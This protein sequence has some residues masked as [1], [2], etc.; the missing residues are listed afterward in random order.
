M[1]GRAAPLLRLRSFVPEG[2][3][4]PPHT[5]HGDRSLRASC[6][7]PTGRVMRVACRCV[8]WDMGRVMRETR[9]E[10][11]DA[12]SQLVLAASGSLPSR[13]SRFSPGAPAPPLDE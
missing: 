7:P 12:H 13:L 6:L 1:C 5:P 9:M 2:H 4:W 8:T 3:L 10:E 11:R